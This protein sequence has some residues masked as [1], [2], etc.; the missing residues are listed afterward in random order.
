MNGLLS[1]IRLSTDE[2]DAQCEKIKHLFW[3]AK[4][5]PPT[6]CVTIRDFH[7]K[8]ASVTGSGS[9]TKLLWQVPVVQT[10]RQVTSRD[11]RTSDRSNREQS[12]IRLRGPGK[13]YCAYLVSKE[14]Q[15]ER[16]SCR[17]GNLTHHVRIFLDSGGVY[18]ARKPLTEHFQ[19]LVVVLRVVQELEGIWYH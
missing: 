17:L 2:F 3:F 19:L 12:F 4:L 11:N 15:K 7:E 6:V 14:R 18:F 10:S 16:R 13:T 1:A 5:R 8:T 9:V